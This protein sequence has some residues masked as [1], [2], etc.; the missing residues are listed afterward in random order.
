[1]DRSIRVRMDLIFF[2]DPDPDFKPGPSIFQCFGF[3]SRSDLFSCV[4]IRNGQKTGYLDPKHWILWLPIRLPFC[5]GVY[6]L[7]VELEAIAIP[8]QTELKGKAAIQ[9]SHISAGEN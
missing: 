8:T 5:L 7:P 3:G 1:M 6:Q 9:E 4:R 2:A